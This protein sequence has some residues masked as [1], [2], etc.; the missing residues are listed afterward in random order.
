MGTMLAGRMQLCPLGLLQAKGVGA[1]LAPVVLL[2]DWTCLKA[3]ICVERAVTSP[4]SPCRYR[5]IDR[6]PVPLTEAVGSCFSSPG[7][8]P[9]KN[10]LEEGKKT[11]NKT[12]DELDPE[13]R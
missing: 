13:A 4:A 8:F 3:E 11:F 10:F 5:C 12:E 9:T 7:E 2:S 6:S 1:G